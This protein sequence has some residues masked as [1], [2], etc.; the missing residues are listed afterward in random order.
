MK[1]LSNDI[2]LEVLFRVSLSGWS[3]VQ[4][5]ADLAVSVGRLTRVATS[6]VT[7]FTVY[8]VYVVLVVSFK[9][10][11]ESASGV[12]VKLAEKPS[13]SLGNLRVTL[14]DS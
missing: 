6:I 12:Q 9:I 11:W 2:V 14:N 3:F 10:C 1:A 13:L 7:S 5:E 8:C 4:P